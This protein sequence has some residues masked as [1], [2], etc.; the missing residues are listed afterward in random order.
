MKQIKLFATIIMLCLIVACSGGSSNVNEV[1]LIPVKIGNDWGYVDR[2]GNMKINP[3]FSAL[4]LFKDGIAVVKP[5]G[6]KGLYGY[7]DE[8][9][10]YI[11]NP[12]FI[13]ATQFTDGIAVVVAENEAPKAINKKGEVLFTLANAE[14]LQEFSDGLAGFSINSDDGKQKWGF[15]DEK[16]QPKINPQFQY[17][18]KFS[19]G[20]AAV[21]NDSGKWGY[22][23][24]EGKFLINPQFDGAGNFKN[25]KAIVI[26]DTKTGVI[27]DKGQ[28]IINPQFSAM[29]E[30]GNLYLVNS[31]GKVGWAD[32]E[33]KLIINPQFDAAGPFN[34]N[35]LA[36]VKSGSTWG[37]IDKKGNFSIA[38]QFDEALPFNGDRAVVKSGGRVGFIDTK[39]K[40]LVNPQFDDINAAYELYV[41]DS[42]KL[43]F[44][45]V[46][47]DYFDA[48]VIT[49]RIKKDITPNTVAGFNFTTPVSDMMAKYNKTT[50][51]YNYYD[52][53]QTYLI[54]N[55]KVGK[56][57]TLNFSIG[58]AIYSS[59]GWYSYD[60]N[61]SANANEFIYHIELNA[62][63][64][65]KSKQIMNAFENAFPGYIKNAESTD[66]NLVFT[67]AQQKITIQGGGYNIYITI[68]PI[69]TNSD[70]E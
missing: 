44:Y 58:G 10:N 59:R 64:S 6:N 13:S 65:E 68:V 38:T 49:D 39:G 24:K 56:F 57:A 8:K 67:S 37:Y 46:T 21:R 35:S 9:G 7:I 53:E 50:A 55:E 19:D 26:L 66:S 29:Q 16:G 33:G 31:G 1:K 11:I 34:G 70:D 41:L 12:T 22:I 25:G 51:D 47:T 30:D 23:D 54:K 28:Y 61:P 14:Q 43:L 60:I 36:P 62:K 40:Y 45:L 63:A 2:E 20:K 18:M 42:N 5:S 48:N 17:V 15:V 52:R 69:V 3:Q 32:K 27:D 4:S